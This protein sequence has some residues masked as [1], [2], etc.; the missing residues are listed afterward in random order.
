M[1]CL[2]FPWIMVQMIPIAD[3]VVKTRECRDTSAD[4]FD[5]SGRLVLLRY[6]SM[7]MTD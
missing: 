6:T 2:K 4:T 5:V 3:C 7:I 1:V